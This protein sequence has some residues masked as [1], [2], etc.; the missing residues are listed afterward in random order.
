VSFRNRLALFFVLIVIVPMLAV[1]FLLFRLIGESENGRA[2]AAIA[3]RHEVAKQLFREQ[4]DLGQIS[5]EQEISRDRVFVSSLQS[6]DRRRAAKRARQLVEFQGIERIVLVRGGRPVLQ[7]GDPTAIAPAIRPVQSTTRRFGRLEVSLIDARTYARRVREVTGLEVVVR[8]GRRVV[9]STLP[10]LRRRALPANGDETSVGG[11]T[12]RVVSFSDTTAFTGQRISVS[13]L[14]SIART[15]DRIRDGRITAASIL[16]G[17]FLIAIACAVLVSRTL[18]RQIAEFLAAA[19]R[20]GG[21]DFSARVPAAGRDEFAALG[22]E[23]NKMSA[24]LERRLAEL[25]QERARF[26]EAVLRLGDAI[27]SNL[28][29]DVLLRVTVEA[30]VEGTGADVGRACIRAPGARALQELAREGN[31]SGLEAA[32]EAAEGEALRAAGPRETS[33]GSAHAIAHPL[34]SADDGREIVGLLSIARAGPAFGTTDRELFTHLAERAAR[35]IENVERHETAA[36]DSVTDKLTELANRRAFDDALA[37]E[38]ERTKR[39]G[40]RF[41]LVMLD[42]DDFG[43]INKRYLDQQGDQVL[44]E[45]GRILRESSREIDHPARYGGEEFVVIVPGTDLDGTYELAERIRKRL[46]DLGIE[47][48]DGE[49]T[50]TVTATCGVAAVPPLAADADAVVAAASAAMRE[51]KQTGK[52]KTVRAR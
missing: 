31:M 42:L 16:L 15:G 41:G 20:I 12:Y 43:A 48:V 47:R 49:G 45:V 9:A 22:E 17:F 7:A 23:F 38:V 14:G 26:Q 4:R 34:Y 8:D 29:R 51:A 28:D 2:N 40:T 24:E 13:T 25:T 3:A 44:R 32:V 1:T 11:R 39:Y 37:S 10:A 21:G 52:N 18:Q 19:R 35:S 50:I 46:A 5:I 30:A 36:R 33:S 6:G 27:A